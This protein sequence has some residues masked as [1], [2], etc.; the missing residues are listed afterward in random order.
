MDEFL[1]CGLGDY[2]Y[3]ADITLL[4][5]KKKGG[6]GPCQELADID[7]K[8]FLLYK[9][10]GQY[11]EIENS[12]MKDQTGGGV[13]KGRALYSSKT[14][15]E[16]HNTTVM[17]CNQKPKLKETPT[18]GDARRICDILFASTFTTNEDDVDEK[19][20]IYLA[21]PLLKEDTWKNDHKVYF[22]NLLFDS[23]VELKQ[24]QY[25]IDKFIPESVKDR[26]NLYL[27]ACFDIHEMFIDNYEYTPEHT[28][29]SLKDVVSVLKESTIF[30]S[31]SKVKQRGMKN[32]MM[33]EFFKTNPG[34]KNIYKERYEYINYGSRVQVRN[35]LL[36][37][38]NKRICIDET[39]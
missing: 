19:N 23:V 37:Y 31:L 15:V 2:F 11:V 10:P 26:S 8:R 9:E 18:T 1:R 38:K 7:K 6:N 4:T 35:I 21:N 3:E 5:T 22:L 14:T 13:I 36:N 27:L 12:N 28:Y 29:V 39:S 20:H 34:Y 30:H 16:L 32:E 33:Y 17:E 25:I 24:E